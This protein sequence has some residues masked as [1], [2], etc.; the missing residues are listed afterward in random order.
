MIYRLKNFVLWNAE[1]LGQGRGSAKWSHRH[2]IYLVLI[3]VMCFGEVAAREVWDLEHMDLRVNYKEQGW[4]ID[5]KHDIHGVRETDEVIV[6]VRDGSFQEAMGAR[7]IRPEDD[8]FQF[9]GIGS[10]EPFWLIPS[11][12]ESWLVWPGIAA[13]KTEIARLH[14]YAEMDSRVSNTPARWIRVALESLR[15]SGPEE[16][17]LSLWQASNVFWSSYLEPVQGNYFYQLAGGH[18]HANWGFSQKGL[19]KIGIRGSTILAEDIETR[20]ES[21]L[22]WLQFFVGSERELWMHQHLSDYAGYPKIK[23][24]ENHYAYG[25]R[26]PPELGTCELV[27][28]T[29]NNLSDWAIVATASG[30]G[31]LELISDNIEIDLAEDGMVWI[32]AKDE[33]TP[34]PFLRLRMICE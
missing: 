14:R 20:I 27:V 29:S 17:H 8:S 5:L 19:Y 24:V 16:G 18:S 13:E 32:R 6:F 7:F 25:F 10:G 11:S 21:P 31:G 15:Y 26:Q 4:K 23:Q 2:V 34:I 9:L 1:L 33:L 3:V 28:E 30:S 22:K 12:Q